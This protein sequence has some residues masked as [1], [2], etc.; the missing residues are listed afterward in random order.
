MTR[1]LQ[2][3][4][5]NLREIPLY[6]GIFEGINFLISRK[7]HG[8]K[9]LRSGPYPRLRENQFLRLLSGIYTPW[10]FFFSFHN[11][12]SK[13]STSLFYGR[14]K[15]LIR[16][17]SEKTYSGLLKIIICNLYSLTIFVGIN[18]WDSIFLE[19]KKG[20]LFRGF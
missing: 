12:M 13:F 8:H 3:L 4:G 9:L 15:L 6:L 14:Q 1:K 11:D 19:V 16:A 5:Q 20:I 18:S 7:F 10:Q 2:K 17:I